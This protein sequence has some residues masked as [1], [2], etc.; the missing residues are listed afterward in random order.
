MLNIAATGEA[1][2]YVTDLG[3]K[4][5]IEMNRAISSLDL[6]GS[7]VYGD[8]P[9]FHV[10]LGKGA[11]ANK[12]GTLQSGSA[13]TL[14]LR[15]ANDASVKAALQRGMMSRG[16]D[17]MSGHAGVIATSHTEQDVAL[18]ATAFYETL[19]EMRESGVLA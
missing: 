13:D 18:T 1:Q 19:K 4:L 7:C 17:L 12:D 6:E 5:V 14:T 15:Q 9:I 3:H 2:R 11:C 8:G 10:L 16:V